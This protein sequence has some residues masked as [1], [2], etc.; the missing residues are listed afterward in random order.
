MIIDILT[1]FPKELE[2]SL[3]GALKRANIRFTNIRDF[4]H[5]NYHSV[6]DSQYGGGKGM[7]LKC[8]P[9]KD[10]IESVK[11]KKSH[12]ILL[13]PSGKKFSQKEALRLSKFNHLILICGH[14]EGVDQRIKNY[15]V[16]EIVSIG[17]YILTGGEYPALVVADSIVR[18]LPGVLKDGV[19]ENESFS[20]KTPLLEFPQYTRPEVFQGHKV[21]KVLLGGNHKEIQKWREKKAKEITSKLRPD[22]FKT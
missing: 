9:V 12:I 6:D 16:D 4:S 7:I 19:T 8:Q 2:N 10:A 14:Y 3:H 22:L 13:D 17:D 18:L 5:N 15:L 20:G 11:G 21:P 1:L